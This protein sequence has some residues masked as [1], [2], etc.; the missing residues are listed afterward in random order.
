[1]TKQSDAN[2]LLME[3]MDSITKYFDNSLDE[4]LVD[5]QKVKELK[6]LGKTAHIKK[7][8]RIKPAINTVLHKDKVAKCKYCGGD[9]FFWGETEWGWRLFD[10]DT[11]QHMCK[12][13]SESKNGQPAAG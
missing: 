10:K 7:K 9:E 1:M 8:R 2:L 12:D 3:I 4:Q 6:H 5:K 13:Q 11:V